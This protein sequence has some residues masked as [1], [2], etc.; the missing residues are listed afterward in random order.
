[1]H[2]IDS[3]QLATV[4][5]GLQVLTAPELQTAQVN[6]CIAGSQAFQAG[7]EQA[8]PGTS[9]RQAG[10]DWMKRCLEQIPN[11]QADR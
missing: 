11:I 4:S 2:T 9:Y 1:M 5:G 3:K 10:G 8:N 6:G 7:L